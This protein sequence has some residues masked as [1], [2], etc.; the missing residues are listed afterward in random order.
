M[1]SQSGVGIAGIL[2]V[3]VSVA[4]GLGLCAILGI[5]FNASTTQVISRSFDNIM[6]F[7]YDIFQWRSSLKK[8]V[9]I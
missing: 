4:A 7:M 9:T 6:N 8:R 1:N 5:A 2:L 3:A